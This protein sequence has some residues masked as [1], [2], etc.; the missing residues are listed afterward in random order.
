MH[1]D[2]AMKTSSLTVAK[3]AKSEPTLLTHLRK[4]QQM[5]GSSATMSPELRRI[6]DWQHARLA[7]TYA[8]LAADARFAPATAFFL[9]ELYGEIGRAHV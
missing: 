7:V 3:V 6:K 1:Y 5:R 8:D 4:L 9:D 2:I